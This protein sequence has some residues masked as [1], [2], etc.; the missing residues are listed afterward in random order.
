MDYECQVDVMLQATQGAVAASQS[1]KSKTKL[2]SRTANPG[3][4]RWLSG[5][6]PPAIAGDRGPTPGSG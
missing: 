2:S 3:L 5:K 6:N 1:G 4:P